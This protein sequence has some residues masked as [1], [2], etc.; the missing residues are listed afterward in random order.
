MQIKLA[1]A[2]SNKEYV[3]RLVS[4][5]EE[6]S[7]LALSV[8]TDS[9]SFVNEAI[10]YKFDVLL[11]DVDMAIDK[12]ILNNIKLPVILY[13]PGKKI[14]ASLSDIPKINKYQPGSMIYKDIIGLYSEKANNIFSIG[15]KTAKLISVFSVVGGNGKTTISLSLAKQL[16]RNS[17]KVLYISFEDV[18]SIDYFFKNGINGN[19]SDI[20]SRLD[21]G[22][23]LKMKLESLIM[24]DS[25]GLNWISGFDNLLD[26]KEIS[27]EEMIKFLGLAVNSALFDFVIIDMG[28]S[29][30]KQNIK[31]LELSDKIVVVETPS[32][33]IATH[34]IN[35]LKEQDSFSLKY[36]RKL[37]SVA[38][39]VVS[40]VDYETVGALIGAV[41]IIKNVNERDVIKVIINSD[42][43]NVSRLF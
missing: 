36:K 37:L 33:E 4:A 16:V 28:T 29:M 9:E 22:I 20:F 17:Y 15:N 24:E 12:R 34:K 6:H 10:K 41:P 39:R 38:N 43:L 27:E 35:K 40:E 42:Y 11:F 25:D 1:I 2:E 13:E 32:S 7:S 8:F 23:D 19:M 5:L 18:D 30:S 26:L 31:V 3:S 14:D 21:S